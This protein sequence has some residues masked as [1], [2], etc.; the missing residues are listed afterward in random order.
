MTTF[1][2]SPLERHCRRYREKDL[3]PAVVDPISQRILLHIGAAYGAV[4]MPTELGER[5]LQRL[6]VA[7]LTG[8]VFAHPRARRWTFL[9][10]PTRHDE[11]PAAAAAE[12]FRRYTTVAGTGSQ[13]VLPSA[14]DEASGYRL[15]VA[16][17]DAH[18]TRPPQNAVIDA[19]CET[20]THSR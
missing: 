11:F 6:R 19:V 18:G 3:L 17:P 14:A 16:G 10:G 13:I 7:G 8:P 5:V 20:G 9:T 4:T 12:L 15:W 1:T 2:E